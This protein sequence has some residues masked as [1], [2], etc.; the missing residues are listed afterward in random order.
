MRAG[1]LCH[2]GQTKML[3]HDDEISAQGGATIDKAI[4]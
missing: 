2:R 4:A 3:S 1:E